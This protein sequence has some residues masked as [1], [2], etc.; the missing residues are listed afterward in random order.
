M[1]LAVIETGGKQYIVAPGQKIKI[2]KIA[3][4]DNEEIVFDQVFLIEDGKK[5]LIGAPLVKGATVTGKVIGQIKSKK[6]VSFRYKA[7]TR[8]K[9]K[10][11]HRQQLTEVEVLKINIAK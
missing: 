5:V 11:G 2:E 1:N 4:K 9:V 7:K 8:S 6:S 10:Q 3:G